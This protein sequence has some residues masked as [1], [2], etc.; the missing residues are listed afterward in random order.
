MADILIIDISE[1]DMDFLLAE[2]LECDRAFCAWF[3]SRAGYVENHHELVSIGRSVSTLHGETDLLIV[4]ACGDGSKRAT[5]IENKVAAPFTPLQPERYR[6]RGTAGVLAG[7]W[8]SYS[9]VLVAPAR[10]LDGVPDGAFDYQ[11]SY[12]DC[13]NA[14]TGNDARTAFKHRM[15]EVA[16]G[17]AKAPWIKTVD[18]G[19]SSWF[20]D[21]RKFAA[22]SFPDLPLPAEGQTRAPTSKW[23]YFAI[24]AF[25][26]ARVGIE[27]KPH[28]GVVDLRFKGVPIGDLRRDLGAAL[29]SECETVVATSAKSIAV[30]TKH[31]PCDLSAAFP[32]Q[33]GVLAPMLESADELV[34][35]ADLYREQIM[36]LLGYV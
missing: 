3:L 33:E 11:I 28:L 27:I 12:E 9:T 2:E 30:R 34:Q 32:G 16:C 25:P 21:A 8:Q 22:G 5:M 1:R 35:F 26:Q 20:Y 10:R 17:K 14:L 18:Q 29:P 15:L 23:F 19:V 13:Q 24:K 7:E 4:H 6:L 36:R 31:V